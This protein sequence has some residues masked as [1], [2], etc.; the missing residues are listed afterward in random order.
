MSAR[1]SSVPRGEPSFYYLYNSMI[2]VMNLVYGWLGVCTFGRLFKVL[3]CFGGG[4]GSLE[5]VVDLC[6]HAQRSAASR[7]IVS[8]NAGLV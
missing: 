8:G 7:E 6:N 4:F 3:L 2:Q 5:L 1:M